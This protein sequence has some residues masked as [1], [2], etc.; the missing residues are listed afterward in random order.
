QAAGSFANT[1]KEPLMHC[2]PSI[3]ARRWRTATLAGAL[4]ACFAC[5]A[6][7]QEPRHT[8]RLVSET[9]AVA[10]SAPLSAQEL[11]DTAVDAYLYAYP[12]VL[13]EATRRS[14]TRVQHALAGKAPMNQFGHRTVFP[15]PGNT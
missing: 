2:R 14:S 9:P 13:L 4:G 1:N 7:A 6:L 15:D 11:R 12:L 3:P 8:L 5:A 10:S